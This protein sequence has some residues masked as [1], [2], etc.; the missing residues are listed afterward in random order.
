MKQTTVLTHSFLIPHSPL[1]GYPVL[2]A[3]VPPTTNNRQPTT[4]QNYRA[5]KNLN[6]FR[7]TN[8]RSR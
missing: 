8:E 1:P 3:P 6:S 7:F 2:S 4:T 5:A